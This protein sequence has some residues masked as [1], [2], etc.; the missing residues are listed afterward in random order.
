MLKENKHIEIFFSRNL[1]FLICNT[2]ILPSH[3]PECIF[4]G[5]KR[6]REGKEVTFMLIQ[7]IFSLK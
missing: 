7:H 4:G 5:A 1:N 2:G 3:S 6:Q